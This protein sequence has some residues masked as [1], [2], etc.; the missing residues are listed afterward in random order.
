M[1]E[2]T[3]IL[4]KPDATI[5]G[6]LGQV[7]QKFECMGFRI[8]GMKFLFLS[9]ELVYGLYPALKHKP[10][11]DQVKTAMQMA[12]SLA[13]VLAGNNAVRNAVKLAGPALKSEEND[14]STIRGMF[15]MWTGADVIHRATTREEAEAQIALFFQEN[16]I[17]NYSRADGFVLSQQ[18]WDSGAAP[19]LST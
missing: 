10:F 3:I 5:R 4:L 12:P 11:H 9:D 16:E 15:S 18:G 7:L 13:L 8:A 14:P 1:M 17:L 6:L 19:F 2:R